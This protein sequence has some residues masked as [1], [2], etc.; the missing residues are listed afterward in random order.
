MRPKAI[1]SEATRVA[2]IEVIVFI[3]NIQL[4]GQKDI[5]TKHLSLA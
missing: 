4:I 1:D 5:E 2:G 3:T